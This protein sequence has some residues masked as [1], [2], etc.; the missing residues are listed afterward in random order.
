MSGRRKRE[1]GRRKRE[2][3][4]GKMKEGRGKRE[5]GRGKREEGRGK[6]EVNRRGS[7]RRTLDM[8]RRVRRAIA[9]YQLP[10]PQSPISN[11]PLPLTPYS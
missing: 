1:E 5:E 10:F 2:E 3:G 6:R 11:Y 8:I 7:A 9:P 4:R